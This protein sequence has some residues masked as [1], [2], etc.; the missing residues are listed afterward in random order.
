[1]SPIYG[2]AVLFHEPWKTPPPGK[3]SSGWLWKAVAISAGV[4]F[5]YYT[6]SPVDLEEYRELPP[7]P[8]GLDPKNRPGPVSHADP[9]NRQNPEE[10]DA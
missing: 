5:L 2:R 6:L 4:A 9:N 3:K 10:S 7:L 8:P 1:M